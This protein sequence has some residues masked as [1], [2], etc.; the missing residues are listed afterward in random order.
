MALNP[1]YML[2]TGAGVNWYPNRP[3]PTGVRAVNGIRDYGTT[4]GAV[5]PQPP[6]VTPPGQEPFEPSPYVIPDM[7]AFEYDPYET[8]T[9]DV[10]RVEELRTKAAAPGVRAATR[11]IQRALMKEYRNPNLARLAMR[12]IL[13]GHG[14]ALS[15]IY[16]G[17]AQTAEMQ[18]APEFAGAGAAARMKYEAGYGAARQKFQL[19]WQG[20][21]EKARADWEVSV[22]KEKR[23]WE[24]SRG[25]YD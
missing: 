2:T 5:S 13:G 18:Y 23:E 22:E 17:A 25:M 3:K 4:G 14:E 11:G 19:G 24:E 20:K 12:D 1:N 10:G 21:I 6:G 9:R 16:G 7:P 15:K 8:P